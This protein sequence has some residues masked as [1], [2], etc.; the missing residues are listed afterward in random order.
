MYAGLKV[1]VVPLEETKISRTKSQR[2]G[3]DFIKVLIGFNFFSDVCIFVLAN[4][5]LYSLFL[6]CLTIA[7]LFSN[8]EIIERCFKLQT[9]FDDLLVSTYGDH[10][11]SS[12]VETRAVHTFSYMLY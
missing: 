11:N 2:N 6:C 1:P 12:D 7:S 4:L 10:L 8:T 3:I 9:I 5:I